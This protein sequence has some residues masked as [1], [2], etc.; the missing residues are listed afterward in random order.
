MIGKNT[1][2]K[3]L[4]AAYLSAQL[5]CDVHLAENQ[6]RRRGQIADED[7]DLILRFRPRDFRMCRSI[8]KNGVCAILAQRDSAS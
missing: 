3:D 7:W 4:I 6:L 8:C 1:S 5:A 2:D